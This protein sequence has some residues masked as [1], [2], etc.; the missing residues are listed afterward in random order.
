MGNG[1]SNIV[2]GKEWGMRSIRED[3]RYP[4]ASGY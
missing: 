3:I 4:P 1:N 2:R